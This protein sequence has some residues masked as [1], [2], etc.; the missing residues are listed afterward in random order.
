MLDLPVNGPY[1]VRP[2]SIRHPG[3]GERFSLG[4]DLR[5]KYSPLDYFLLMFPPLQLQDMVR[6][7]N[8]ELTTKN[9]PPTTIGEILKW[10]GILILATR[11]EF[12][13]RWSL[14]STGMT[15]TNKYIPAACFG[16]TGMSRN[17]FDILWRNICYGQQPKEQPQRNFVGVIKMDA[18]GWFCEVV[19]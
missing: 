4:H 17:R 1:P 2:C 18:C 7:T 19:Q 12:G 10:I 15:G 11:F 9:T 16:K 13:H 5:K 8:L 3:T 14:W 6:L